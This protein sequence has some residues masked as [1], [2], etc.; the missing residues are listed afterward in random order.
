ME[1]TLRDASPDE[2]RQAREAQSRPLLARLDVVRHELAARS[3]PKSPVGDALRYLD[4]QWLALQRYVADG[5]LII[6]N[7]NA[8]R[9]LRTV[10]VGRNNW[11]F[12]GSMDGAHRAALLYSLIQSCRLAGVP[13]F[14]YLRDVLVRVATHPHHA[15][16]QLTPKG[17]AAAFGS[18][19][20]A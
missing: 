17:W 1:R 2:R 7:N 5:D 6:D 14:P 11:L 8:E 19:A 3:L 15:I 16:H 12:A 4:H 20:S 9:Q 10:A 18:T 13:P